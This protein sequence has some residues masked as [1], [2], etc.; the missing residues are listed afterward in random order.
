VA[1]G[2]SLATWL[3]HSSCL[4]LAVSPYCRLLP[5][6]T[7]CHPGLS[8]HSP[9]DLVS[10]RLAILSHVAPV[11]RACNV[12]DHAPSLG[13]CSIPAFEGL[14]D[15]PHNKRVMKLLYRTSEWHGLAKLRMHTQ[16]TLEHLDSLTKE[17]GRLMRCFR[18]VTCSQF[19]TKELPREVAAQ[20]RAQARGPTTEPRSI[21]GPRRPKT[22]NLLTPKFHALGDYVQTIKTFGTT[23][24]FSTQVV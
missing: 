14:L 6:L 9:S 15:E 19:Q 3:S 1:C 21:P 17:Y 13:Q 16:A 10:R 23:D 8:C 22:L 11:S 4:W 18:E 12:T 20:R 24:S 7:R 5:R 2:I